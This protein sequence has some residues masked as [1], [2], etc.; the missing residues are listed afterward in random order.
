MS[1]SRRVASAA[2]RSP[3]SAAA[4]GA[5]AP[6]QNVAADDG[7]VGDQMALERL[8]RVQA[9][10]QQ[11]LHG[12]GQLGRLAASFL[13][14]PLHHLLGEQRVA[15]GA[16]GERVEHLGFRAG[17]AQQRSRSARACR[18]GPADRGT[19]SSSCAATPPQPGRRSSSSSRVRH[20]CS[21]GARSHCDRYSIR[22]SMPSSAQWMSSQASTS[23]S[24]LRERLQKARTAPKKRSRALCASSPLMTLLPCRRRRPARSRAG[25]RAARCRRAT[26]VALRRRSQAATRAAARQL[27]PGDLRRVAVDDLALGAQH[28]AER[29][30]D[31]ARAER[32]GIVPLRTR[33]RRLA[34]RRASAR[35][36]A[37]AASCPRRPGRTPSTRCGVPSRADSRRA[38]SAGWRT[39]RGDRPAAPRGAVCERRRC[40]P[41]AG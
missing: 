29:P 24:T 16:L 36:R 14:E 5:S 4:T 21:T 30:V 34:R 19:G 32:A 28:F 40:A 17:V 10:G 12:V 20:T 15:L 3:P 9:R 25:A 35:T 8:E 6:S 7:R 26:C 13:G 41:R 31:D 2:C 27:R 1:F 22:S 23:G 33:T 18:P 39:R 37:A 11:P 38:A